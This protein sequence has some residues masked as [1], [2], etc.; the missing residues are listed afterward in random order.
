MSKEVEK[1]NFKVME[2][3][4]KLKEKQKKLEEVQSEMLKYTSKIGKI[5]E[6]QSFLEE[7]ITNR[8]IDSNDN[9]FEKKTY[10]FEIIPVET[11]CT[12]LIIF[13][14]TI[15]NWMKAW[16]MKHNDEAQKNADIYYNITNGLQT[17]PK[18]KFFQSDTG[19][20][21]MEALKKEAAE[22][23]QRNVKLEAQLQK[24]NEAR[25]Q[26]VWAMED[27]KKERAKD[28]QRIAELEAK[29]K[30][31]EEK[32]NSDIDK[33][34]FQNKLLSDPVKAKEKL[35]KE[36]KNPIKAAEKGQLN[37]QSNEKVLLNSSMVTGRSECLEQENK[38][39]EIKRKSGQLNIGGHVFRKFR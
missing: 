2:L 25:D 21:A 6:D 14:L 8:N 18:Q 31:Q 34:T 20:W 26:A 38:L 19:V 17:T 32:R 9:I 12:F 23:K 37:H 7:N 3:E 36:G 4:N 22:D 24:I 10:G 15:F 16:W 11:I 5:I 1:S 28:K 33:L 39:K 35:S 30:L 29:L 13:A 27:L